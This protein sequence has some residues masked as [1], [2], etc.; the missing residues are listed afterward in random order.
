MSF[1]TLL[2]GFQGREARLFSRRLCVQ[3]W[4]A[5]SFNAFGKFRR[6]FFW[7]LSRIKLAR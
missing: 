5:A 4:A 6:F 1:C 3:F 2:F 7:V